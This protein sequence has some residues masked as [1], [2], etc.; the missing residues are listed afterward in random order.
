VS[1]LS[2]LVRA[3][4]YFQRAM[5]YANMTRTPV[6]WFLALLAAEGRWIPPLGWWL[7]PMALMALGAMVA[8]GW[9]EHRS[10]ALT[11][12]QDFYIGRLTTLKEL[13]A[14]LDQLLE[15]HE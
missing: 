6:L 12:E 5:G 11:V 1:I 10:G 4:I 3:K 15:R 8:L 14:K 9:L 2:R 7:V 13:H